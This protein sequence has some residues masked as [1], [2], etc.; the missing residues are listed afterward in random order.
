M[1]VNSTVFQGRLVAEP[2]FGQTTSTG[3]DFANF[4]LAWSKKYKDKETKCFLECK[5]FGTTAQFMQKY[6]NQKGQ[7]IIAEGELNTDEW[8][9]DGQKRSKTV[10][11]VERVHFAGSK[12]GR[13]AES[14][15]DVQPSMAPAQGG[16][17][18][19]E[20]DSLPF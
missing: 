20:T 15:A 7:E 11:S 5:T 10:L 13:T 14:T 8:E 16:F 1:A 18:A 4:R 19:V 6:M 9:K 17:T 12:Q 3:T 2:T